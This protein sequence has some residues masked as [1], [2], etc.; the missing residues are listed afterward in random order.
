MKNLLLGSLIVAALASPAGAATITV[1]NTTE[2]DAAAAQ[3][4][5]GDV[6]QLKDGSTLR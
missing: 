6:V 5:P 3:A 2:L 1:S 4:Q